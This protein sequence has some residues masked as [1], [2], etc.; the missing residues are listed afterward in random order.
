MDTLA[1]SAATRVYQ[2]LKRAILERIHADGALLSEAEIAAD[3]GVSRT[4][5]R[6]ALLRL[7]SEGLVALYPKRGVLVRPVSAAEIEDVIDA[8]RLVEVH[9]AQ[10][11]WERRATLVDTLEPWLDAMRGAR[12]D[13]DVVAL[14]IAD[15][16]FHAAVVDGGG[17][18]ILS[19][20]YQ[21][22]RDRQMRIGI[23][24]MRVEPER[25]DQA[26][27]DHTR[28]LDALRGDDVAHWSALVDEHILTTATRLRPAR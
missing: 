16:A 26:V 19:E 24:A 25:V 1:P 2:H 9:A 22:L 27:A 5:V 8:R 4:P 6:E 15:R 13:G 3:V 11:A 14:M 12:R 17:N 18:A 10:R 23:A 21:R 20:L 7:E 28:L